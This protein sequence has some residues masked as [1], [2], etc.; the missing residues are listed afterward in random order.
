MKAVST[1]QDPESDLTDSRDRSERATHVL[2]SVV[3]TGSLRSRSVL[4]SG[5]AYQ[6]F[7][8]P[9]PFFARYTLVNESSGS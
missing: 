6:P 5:E 9:S 4:P 8:S 7:G 3:S 1:D 2:S